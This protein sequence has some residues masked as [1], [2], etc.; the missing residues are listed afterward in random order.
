M[1]CALGCAVAEDLGNAITFD[2]SGAIPFMEVTW[3]KFA[4]LVA[5][6]L[7][8]SASFFLIR[9]ALVV[10]KAP[11]IRNEERLEA[12]NRAYGERGALEGRKRAERELTYDE[13]ASCRL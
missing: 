9:Y 1:C 4:V 8:V 6:S 2:F 12:R 13:G 10:A 11:L 7:A 5:V 3:A